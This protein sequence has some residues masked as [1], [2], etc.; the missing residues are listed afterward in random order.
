MSVQSSP[1]S[2]RLHLLVL[3]VLWR[4][5]TSPGPQ[6]CPS[7]RHKQAVGASAKYLCAVAVT[8]ENTK[9]CNSRQLSYLATCGRA[10]RRRC[11]VAVHVSECSLMALLPYSAIH[12]KPS[13][14]KRV[15]VK[16]V[17]RLVNTRR[18]RKN[19]KKECFHECCHLGLRGLGWRAGEAHD[20]RRHAGSA[21]APGRLAA[22]YVSVSVSSISRSPCR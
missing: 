4:P 16:P 5:C 8:T 10:L 7:T 14:L 22:G 13:N 21:L 15:A 19:D 11:C 20:W 2:R 3:E 1:A 6:P 9:H 12:S 18:P 17:G